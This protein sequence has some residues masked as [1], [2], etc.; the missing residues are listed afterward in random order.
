VAPELVEHH[1]RRRVALEI[2]DD[3]DA[4]AAGLV[5]N[6]R[7]A[8]DPLV[9]RGFGDLFDQTV[10]AGLVRDFGEHDRAAVAAPFL[11]DVARTHDDRAAPGAIGGARAGLAQDQRAG[12]EIGCGDDLHQLFERD[13]RIVHRRKAGAQHFAEIVRRDVGRHADRNAARTVDQQVREAGGKHGAAPAPIR[14]SS[15]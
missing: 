7:D 5:A 8:L 15:A 10:L 11:D 6:V 2:N 4:L 1:I 12:R 13:Q 14:H 9:L 3:A